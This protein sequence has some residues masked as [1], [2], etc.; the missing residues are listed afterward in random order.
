MIN[1]SVFTSGQLIKFICL[2]AAK[3]IGP[4][5]FQEGISRGMFSDIAEYLADDQYLEPHEL[6]KL[7]RNKLRAVLGLIPLSFR[8]TVDCTQTLDQMLSAHSYSFIY[9][10]IGEG[11]IKVQG[12]GSYETDAELVPFESE[13]VTNDA[14]IPAAVEVFIQELSAAGNRP[15]NLEELIAF[16]TNFSTLPNKV[17]VVALGARFK[18][19][20][21]AEEFIGLKY[22]RRF[23]RPQLVAVTME[24][25]VKCGY[26]I[27]T[28][29]K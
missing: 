1:R 28:V 4:Q 18:G 17:K 14:S 25:V 20:D 16:T 19:R 22:T 8:M 5:R 12:S 24:E 2:L 3:G 23:D 27:L 9:C 7:D 21:G 13:I 26:H 29:P 11:E 6:R 15:A 10:A